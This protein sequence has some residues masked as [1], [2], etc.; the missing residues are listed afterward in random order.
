MLS[1]KFT[2]VPSENRGPL[3]TWNRLAPRN[4]VCQVFRVSLLQLARPGTSA[5]LMMS[6]H[7]EWP[8]ILVGLSV[9]NS[10][11]NSGLKSGYG[12]FLFILVW[13]RG[14]WVSVSSSMQ[15]QLCFKMAI[16]SS[17]PALGWQQ[18]SLTLHITLVIKITSEKS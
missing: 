14:L 6:L 2:S 12:V 7:P 11:L 15:L 3:S 4:I 9:C 17:Y 5:V 10:G 1:S 8:C 13:K 16:H 18:K